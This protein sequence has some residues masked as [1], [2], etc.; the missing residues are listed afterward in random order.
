MLNI[1]LIYFHS[2]TEFH[3]KTWTALTGQKEHT[4]KRRGQQEKECQNRTLRRWH[5]GKDRQSSTCS[6]NRTASTE[7]AKA[8]PPEHDSQTQDS[9]CR[10]ARRGQARQHSR[11]KTAMTEQPG[12][13]PGD[14]SQTGR[15]EQDSH[16]AQKES[17]RQ[18]GV[19]RK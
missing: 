15:P 9:W 6:Q 18:K 1:I 16:N 12:R 17:N 5:Q 4:I 7:R 2:Y 14:D 11:D 3:G 19:G 10:T 8:R 13:Q